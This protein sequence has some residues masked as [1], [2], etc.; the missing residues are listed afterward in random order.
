V[1]NTVK[2]ETVRS[3]NERSSRTLSR[4]PAAALVDIRVKRAV[5]RETVMRDC[6]SM[7]TR[8]A[9]SYAAL[10]ATRAD[11]PPAVPAAAAT[12]ETTT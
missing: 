12:F 8:K 4:S 1:A 10:P 6:G 9:L 7:K 3:P 5:T 11:V 2:T